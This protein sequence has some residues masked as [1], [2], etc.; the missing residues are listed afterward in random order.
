MPIKV[1]DM[2]RLLEADGRVWIY[3]H[4]IRPGIVVLPGKLGR[5]IPSGTERSIRRQPGLR[6][7]S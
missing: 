6:W 1:R 3:A 2:I 7:L 5:D 4:P